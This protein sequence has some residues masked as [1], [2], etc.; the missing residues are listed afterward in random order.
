[1]TKAELRAEI[2]RRLNEPTADLWS[3]TDIDAFARAEILVLPAKNVYKEEIYSTAFVEDQEDYLLP[4]GTFK[5]EK[6]EVDNGNST[7]H[8]W[9]QLE[10]GWDHY[11]GAIWFSPPPNTTDTFRVFIKMAFTDLDSYTDGQ[12]IDVPDDKTE[13]VILGATLRAYQSLMGYF[14]DLKNWDYNVKPDG[15]TMSQVQSWIRDVKQEY[16]DMVRICRRLPVPRFIS[17]VD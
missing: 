12:E 11:A 4:T 6:V 10:S 3:N 8:D 14:V 2:R 9:Q 13:V 1:M 15:I 7:S 5:V 16:L 17:L